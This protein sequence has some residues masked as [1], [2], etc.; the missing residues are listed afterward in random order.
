MYGRTPP[1]RTSEAPGTAAIPEA[2][3]LLEHAKSM[4]PRS[5]RW[6]NP[7]QAV[8]DI[9]LS[10]VLVEECGQG[11][12]LAADVILANCLAGNQHDAGVRTTTRQD[13]PVQRG[14]VSGIVRDDRPP[15]ARS[16]R[17]QQIIGQASKRPRLLLERDNVVT[18]LTKTSRECRG[19]MAVQPEPEHPALTGQAPPYTCAARSFSAMSVSISS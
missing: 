10:G 8:P 14:E 19:K 3:E 7:H 13:G 1:W 12:H 9:W 4:T 17:Q 11:P 18:P 5:R 16:L 2:E 6:P 15:L